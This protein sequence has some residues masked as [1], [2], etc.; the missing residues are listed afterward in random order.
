MKQPYLK[1]LLLI[2]V[3][4]PALFAGQYDLSWN[5]VDGGGLTFMTGGNFTLGGTTG[6]PDPGP[7]TGAN[8][9]LN[10]GFWATT[11]HLLLTISSSASGWPVVPPSVPASG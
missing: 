4:A 1:F 7:L 8:F 2:F 5:T 6:Q 11:D 10:G 3:S 9:V